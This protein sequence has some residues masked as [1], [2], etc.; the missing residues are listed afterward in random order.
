MPSGLLPLVFICFP[1]PSLENVVCILTD[2]TIWQG[3]S[4]NKLLDTF[5]T[6]RY[7]ILKSK[8]IKLRA[9]NQ[10]NQP[11][12][13]QTVGSGFQTGTNNISRATRMF[14]IVLPGKKFG[15]NG[16]LQ[17]ENNSPQPKFFDYHL[18]FLAYSNYS[19]SDTLGFNVARVND[20]FVK[21]N[22]K[23]A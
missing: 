16:I 23:D 14:T 5:N 19:T 3:A 13:T 8:F 18:I 2:A 21:L 17:Y 9:P 11:I 10:G 15:R 12:G 22:Y 1:H 4:A 6:E 7:T 20:V